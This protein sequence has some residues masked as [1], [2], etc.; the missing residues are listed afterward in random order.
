MRLEGEVKTGWKL[1]KSRSP[2]FGTNEVEHCQAF[3]ALPDL[4]THKDG[5]GTRAANAQRV[6][7]R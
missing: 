2:R 7:K 5:A 4:D 6:S 3:S 1:G